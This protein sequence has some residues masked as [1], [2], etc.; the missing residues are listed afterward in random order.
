MRV[1]LK[2]DTTKGEV[3]LKADTTC[4]AEAAQQRRRAK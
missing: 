3:R 4:L 1:R 2:A